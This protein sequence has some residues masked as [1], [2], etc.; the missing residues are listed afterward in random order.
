MMKTINEENLFIV[1]IKGSLAL[2]AIL[3]IIGMVFFSQKTGLGILAGG[4]IAIINFI[5]MR[6][7]LQRVLGLLP[8]NPNRYALMRY[9]A[10]M[11]VMGTAL[12]L[13]LTSKWFSLSGLL[14]GLSIIVVNIITLSIFR[15]LRTGG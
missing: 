3:T 8:A 2:L 11:I 5:W 15:A 6:N 12:Y 9:I 13:I 1:I 10:R 14:V 7:I 4:G